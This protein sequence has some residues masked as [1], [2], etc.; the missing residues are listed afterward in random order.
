M[1]KLTK[2]EL[3]SLR[4]QNNMVIIK[5][6]EDRSKYQ[7]TKDI[8][9]KLDIDFTKDA[10]RY[11]G[12]IN[13]VVAVPDKIIF[14]T[15]PHDRD[16]RIQFSEWETTVELEVGDTVVCNYFDLQPSVVSGNFIVCE[17]CTYYYIRYSDIYCKIKNFSGNVNDI[18]NAVSMNIP[19]YLIPI[20]GYI[21]AEPIFK[22]EGIGAYMVDKETD[23]ALVKYVGKKNTKYM[24]RYNQNGDYMYEP[25]DMDVQV[26]DIIHFK[27]Y[28]A[29]AM[30]NG[31]AKYFGSLIPILGRD[32]TY[33]EREGM[34]YG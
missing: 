26:S 21:L 22:K 30:D 32:V 11:I 20:N 29:H 9:L 33:H 25:M 19:D 17:G 8:E 3:L 18:R 31:L 5:S 10:F 27:K 6:L 15:K 2:E 7:L 14:G 1:I 12:V 28:A 4:P 24:E 34:I 16:S 13:Q 23:H